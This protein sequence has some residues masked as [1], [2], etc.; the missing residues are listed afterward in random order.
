VLALSAASRGAA[1]VAATG[2]AL[3]QSQRLAKSVT[4]AFV[5]SAQ[6]FPEVRDAS[7]V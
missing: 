5:G 4:Q 6:A 1:Q 2:Q 7:T 3:M